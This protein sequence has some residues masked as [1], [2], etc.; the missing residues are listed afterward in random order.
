[1]H[2]T[3]S[4][5]FSAKLS[6]HTIFA[7]NW[8]SGFQWRFFIFFDY[9]LFFFCLVIF[10]TQNLKELFQILIEGAWN[11]AWLDFLEIQSV[12]SKISFFFIFS[13]VLGRRLN[14]NDEIK[15]LQNK[16]RWCV[17]KPHQVWLCSIWCYLQWVLPAWVRSSTIRWVLW[18]LWVF[19]EIRWVTEDNG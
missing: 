12:E 5:A 13:F 2:G 11:F 7:W 8:E 4:L 9:F 18:V 17:T 15:A 6:G 19:R 1:M 14:H 3:E 16:Q 10:T